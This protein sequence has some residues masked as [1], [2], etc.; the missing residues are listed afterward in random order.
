MQL[1]FPCSGRQ[2][3]PPLLLP[4]TSLSIPSACLFPSIETHLLHQ[5]SGPI[6]NIPRVTETNSVERVVCE[7]SFGLAAP[8]C[9]LPPLASPTGCIYHLIT[10][11]T[12]SS[13]P[14]SSKWQL[15]SLQFAASCLAIPPTKK[16][17]SSKPAQNYRWPQLN[18]IDD[19]LYLH[20]E[21]GHSL[22][23]TSSLQH[24]EL[25]SPPAPI[26]VIGIHRLM[27]LDFSVILICPLMVCKFYFKPPFSVYVHFVH[28]L[29]T[30]SCCLS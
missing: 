7:C 23:V 27:S 19:D 10:N 5:R 12:A 22:C 17:S 2:P 20:P 28:A 25:V 16:F 24:E 6:L 30:R 26:F 4:S 21:F 18:D 3:N 15:Q 11:T 13:V 29:H 14:S 8:D 1:S 9:C